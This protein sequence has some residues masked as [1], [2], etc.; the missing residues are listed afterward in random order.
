MTSWRSLSS[1]GSVAAEGPVTTPITRRGPKGT[2]TRAP[3]TG[4]AHPSGTRY[5]KGTCTGSGNAT[6]TVRSTTADKST[7]LACAEGSRLL[8]RHFGYRGPVPV[9]VLVLVLVSTGGWRCR[10]L[11]RLK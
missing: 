10:F 5:E 8:Q 7:V 6:S 9:L 4:T 11:S 2:V 3:R 1:R